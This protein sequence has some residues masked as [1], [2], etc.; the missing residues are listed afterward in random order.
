MSS[1]FQYW[2][3]VD[4]S[5]EGHD[6]RLH[7][8][9]NEAH[10][11][12]YHGC[13]IRARGCRAAYVDHRVRWERGFTCSFALVCFSFWMFVCLIVGLFPLVDRQTLLETHPA[14]DKTTNP[15]THPHN[16]PCDTPLRPTQA[17]HPG[18]FVSNQFEK[19]T[20]TLLVSPFGG[21][22]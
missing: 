15:A 17:T 7:Q 6:H 3:S 20:H 4:P 21:C 9:C 22:R 18:T 10:E 14:I 5:L 1:L 12:E 11:R 16:P 8:Y 19:I 13:N 2:R